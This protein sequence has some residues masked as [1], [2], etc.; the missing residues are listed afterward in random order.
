MAEVG[1]GGGDA[2]GLVG[3]QGRATANPTG[4]HLLKLEEGLVLLRRGGAGHRNWT[5]M[6]SPDLHSYLSKHEHDVVVV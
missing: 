2:D 1:V 3:F 4:V 5:H 6:V